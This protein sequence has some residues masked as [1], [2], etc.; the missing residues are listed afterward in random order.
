MLGMISLS[1]FTLTAL[2][3]LAEVRTEEGAW[4]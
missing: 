4:N 1:F 2:V 3:G